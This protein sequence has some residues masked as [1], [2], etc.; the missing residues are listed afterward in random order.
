MCVCVCLKGYERL[1][2][3]V[4]WLLETVYLPFVLAVVC[5]HKG[6]KTHGADST[7]STQ[8]EKKAAEVSGASIQYTHTH[9]H[10]YTHLLLRTYTHKA[11]G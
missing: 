11:I 9:T 5:A 7:H 2:P 4:K 1:L 10:T 3:S 6:D 8:A